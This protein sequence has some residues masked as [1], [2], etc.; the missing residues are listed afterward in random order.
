MSKKCPRRIYLQ[1]CDKCYAENSKIG[2]GI[3]WCE[4]EIGHE[5]DEAGAMDIEYI[6]LDALTARAKELNEQLKA[7]G[8]YDQVHFDEETGQALFAGMTYE[9][10]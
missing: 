6:R 9:D 7:A 8:L 1:A 3:T 10:K 5:C 2:D 4:D